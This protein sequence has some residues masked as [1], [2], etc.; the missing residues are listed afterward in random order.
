ML[1]LFLLFSDCFF[2]LSKISLQLLQPLLLLNNRITHLL[3]TLLQSTSL[4]LLLPQSP[5]QPLHFLLVLLFQLLNLLLQILYHRLVQFCTIIIVQP[6]QLGLQL[7]LLVTQL[8]NLN[9]I[10]NL[11]FSHQHQLRLQVA[12]QLVNLPL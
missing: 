2:R 6:I 9:V 3:H 5:L 7:L 8:F 1:H 12:L 11:R 10:C 4:I